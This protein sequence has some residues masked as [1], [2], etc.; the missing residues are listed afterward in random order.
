M[1]SSLMLVTAL[2]PRIGYENAARVAKL[3]F[4]EN[5]TLR[6]AAVDKLQVRRT[7][8]RHMLDMNKRVALNKRRRFGLET[9]IP[10]YCILHRYLTSIRSS[11][12]D[13]LR[14]FHSF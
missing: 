11:K 13:V 5:C 9:L 2:N 14:C 8:T 7:K 3:A 12:Y 4:K 6:E 1:R 10:S